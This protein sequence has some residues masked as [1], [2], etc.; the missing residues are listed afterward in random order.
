MPYIITDDCIL[1]G[2]CAAGCPADAIEEGDTKCEIDVDI[3][4]ECGTCEANCLSGAIVFVEEEE[5]VPIT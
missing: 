2:V 4:I 5:R 1:C 3:C